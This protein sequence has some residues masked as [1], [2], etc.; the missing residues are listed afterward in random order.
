MRPKIFLSAFLSLALTVAS[1]SASALRSDREH[2]LQL[3]RGQR[4]RQTVW[5]PHF[6]SIRQSLWNR[7]LRWY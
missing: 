7:H 6:R 4:R 2:S 5:T 1:L 3:Y